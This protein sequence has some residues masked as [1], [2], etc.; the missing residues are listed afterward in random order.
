MEGSLLH[1]PSSRPIKRRRTKPWHSR[2]KSTTGTLAQREAGQ[3]RD[4]LPVFLHVEHERNRPA[5]LAMQKWRRRLP[6]AERHVERQQRWNAVDVA[7]F[8]AALQAHMD[9]RRHQLERSLPVAM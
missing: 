8:D 4:A 9:R 7:V 3:P 2:T 5:V 1:G 6:E